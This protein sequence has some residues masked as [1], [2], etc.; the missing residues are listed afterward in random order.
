MA[1]LRYCPN[2]KENRFVQMK[3]NW[4]IFIILLILGIILG[5]IYL[6]YCYLSKQ[7]CPVCGM[8]ANLMEPPRNN[9]GGSTE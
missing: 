6:L 9:S 2:C 8:P 3:I 1:E 7:E 4:I 5:I